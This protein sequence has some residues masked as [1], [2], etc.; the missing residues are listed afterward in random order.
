MAPYIFPPRPYKKSKA[1]AEI[2]AGKR[3]N[4]HDKYGPA[5][6]LPLIA[7]P[8]L[9]KAR[10]IF[11]LFKQEEGP[12][13]RSNILVLVRSPTSEPFS[14][15][16]CSRNICLQKAV[17]DINLLHTMTSSHHPLYTEQSA[18]DCW[19]EQF[20]GGCYLMA[21]FALRFVPF[22]GARII[23]ICCL[24]REYQLW[25]TRNANSGA[26]SRFPISFVRVYF[27]KRNHHLFKNAISRPADFLTMEY[28]SNKT[29]T[30]QKDTFALQG[31]TTWL[32]VC[33]PV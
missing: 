10:L 11:P 4:Y 18:Y 23:N 1:R 13:G 20:H 32:W 6:R 19:C 29:Q 28:P 14:A 2:Q 27:Q 16:I 17:G 30:Y 15:L 7:Y 26:A 22:R 25:R 31:V 12:G 5:T 33:H 21:D 24:V 9:W 8:P 3:P